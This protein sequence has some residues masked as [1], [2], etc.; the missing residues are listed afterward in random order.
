[1]SERES[2]SQ[3]REFAAEI[4]KGPVW[5]LLLPLALA[6]FLRLASL[7]ASVNPQFF[8]DAHG[9]RTLSAILFGLLVLTVAWTARAVA[10][11]VAGLSAGIVLAVC[12]PALILSGLQAGNVALT[13]A[14][15]IGL[16]LV[17]FGGRISGLGW[18]LWALIALLLALPLLR[19]T[20]LGSSVLL[21]VHPSDAMLHFWRKQIP[22]LAP[23]I[24]LGVIPLF[25]LGLSSLLV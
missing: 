22:L 14:L 24:S 10:G 4:R 16:A 18:A 9:T 1:M 12:W 23:G 8:P 11:A 19:S 20:Q 21:P 3:E 2:N 13:L 6:I 5:L 15:L 7:P 17:C 25:A